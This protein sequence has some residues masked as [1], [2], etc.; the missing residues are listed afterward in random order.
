MVVVKPLWNGWSPIEVPLWTLAFRHS[1][2]TSLLVEQ[3]RL[4]VKQI[5]ELEQWPLCSMFKVHR[6]SWSCQESQ[7]SHGYYR[8]SSKLNLNIEHFVQ[9]LSSRVHLHVWSIVMSIVSNISRL[10]N[11]KIELFCSSI[12]HVHLV[13]KINAFGAMCPGWQLNESAI[14]L[15]NLWKRFVFIGS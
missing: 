9:S 6:F 2:F 5:R 13:I 12:V 15:P 1:L 10:L 14:F 3:I 8:S 4:L 7:S 11:L